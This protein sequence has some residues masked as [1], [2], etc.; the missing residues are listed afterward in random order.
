MADREAPSEAAEISL[1]QAEEFAGLSDQTLEQL[2]Q[3]VESAER[4]LRDQMAPF[5]LRLAKLA[6]DAAVVQTEVRRRERQRHIQARKEVRTQ[7][8][9]GQAPS[10][11]QLVEMAEPPPFGEPSFADLTFLLESGGEVALGYP[12]SRVPSLQMTDGSATSTVTTLAEARDLYR[13]GWEIGVPARR[14]VRVHTPG[15]RLE[16]LLDPDKCFVR[17]ASAGGAATPDSS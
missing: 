5:Q 3:M 13:Q 14:G 1:P 17:L 6:K 11:G 7:V 12:G 8:T 2:V 15:T 16:R 4:E 9:E 10:L